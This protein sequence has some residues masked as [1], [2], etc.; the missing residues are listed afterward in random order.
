MARDKCVKCGERHPS[1]AP[2]PGNANATFDEKAWRKAYMKRYMAKLR[3]RKRAE[4]AAAEQ[5]KDQAS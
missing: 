3:A 1:N 4:K 5:P 2:C